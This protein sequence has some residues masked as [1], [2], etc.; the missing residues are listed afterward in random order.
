MRMVTVVADLV[1]GLLL[2]LFLYAAASRTWPA[3]QRPWIAAL[4][5]CG[6]VVLVLYRRPGGTLA[7]RQ[8]RP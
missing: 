4:I 7:R 8:P 5:L 6:A 1:M 3:L 2:G